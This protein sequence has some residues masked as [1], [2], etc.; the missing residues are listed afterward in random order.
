MGSDFIAQQIKAE[1]RQKQ[2]WRDRQLAKQLSSQEPPGQ[3]AGSQSPHTNAFT[4]LMSSQPPAPT[5][6]DNEDSLFGIP[7]AYDA[8]WDDSLGAGPSFNIPQRRL[9]PQY[10]PTSSSTNRPA[11]REDPDIIFAGSI[12]KRSPARMERPGPGLTMGYPDLTRRSQLMQPHPGFRPPPSYVPGSYSSPSSLSDIIARNNGLDP[13]NGTYQNG[14]P[15]HPY[16]LDRME[17]PYDHGP[18]LDESELQELLKNISADMDLPKL[19]PNDAP[20]GLKR[21]LYPHQDIALAWMK[22]MEEGTSKGGIL[23]DDMGLGKTISTLA[24]LLARPATTR[25]KVCD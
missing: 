2:E 9:D 24:L 23:A 15:I 6:V 1:D 12:V 5:I 22:K 25:P 11:I 3:V 7:G 14:D 19:D 10:I 21:P 16:I 18:G 17:T 8:R 13:I 20:A 4:R